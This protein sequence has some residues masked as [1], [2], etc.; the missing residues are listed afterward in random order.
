MSED[1]KKSFFSRLDSHYAALEMIKVA[2]KALYMVAAL[3]AL[4]ALMG[5]RNGL[6]DAF[7]NAA[8][9]FGIGRYRSR[10][11]SGIAL[12]LAL[13]TLVFVGFGLA[14]GQGMSGLACVVAALAAWAAARAM[15][16]TIKVRGSLAN[17]PSR[18]QSDNE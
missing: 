9:A 13:G 14:G 12:L 10:V 15:E 5:D 1:S 2:S 18:L 3:Q 8:C 11:A 16:A 6:I 17:S 7:V 4:A